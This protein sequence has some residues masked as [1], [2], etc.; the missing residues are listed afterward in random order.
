ME[1]GRCDLALDY[2][3]RAVAANPE[4]AQAQLNLGLAYFAVQRYEDALTHFANAGSLDPQIAP[5]TERL[6]DE[7]RA[8][9]GEQ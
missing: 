8:R 6:I 2:L 5:T 3:G 7:V 1:L 9:L 4:N